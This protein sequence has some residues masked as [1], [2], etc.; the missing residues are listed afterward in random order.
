[1]LK[2]FTKMFGKEL[3]DMAQKIMSGLYQNNEVT[4]QL[5]DVRIKSLTDEI[6][7]LMILRSILSDKG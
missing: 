7:N 5:I 3:N 4:I 2:D 6:N 1:M